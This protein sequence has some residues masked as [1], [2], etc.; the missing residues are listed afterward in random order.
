MK[1]EQAVQPYYVDWAITHRCNLRCVHCRGMHDTELPTERAL[2]LLQEIAALAPGWLIIEGGE[3][4]MRPDLFGILRYAHELGLK[5]FIISNGMLLTESA[6]RWCAGM[7]IRIMLSMDSPDSVTFEN[8]RRGAMFPTVLATA[9]LC[10]AAGI[11]DAINCT[12]S[13]HNLAQLPALFRLAA[14]I[15]ARRLH[16]LGLKP[17]ERYTEQLL[18]PRE[19]RQAI[20]ECCRAS[21]ETGVAFF[22]DEPFFNAAVREW[23]CTYVPEGGGSSITIAH[24]PGCILGKYLFITPGG[25]VWPCSFSPLVMGNVSKANL[26]SVWEKM[27]R[28]E[29]LRRLMDHCSRE[30][31]CRGCAYLAECGGCRARAYRLSKD[32]CASDPACP[33]HKA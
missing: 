22:F 25:D 24:E 17:C 18:S 33:L 15:G 27:R 8:L 26:V 7:G 1:P 30:G 6:V 32:W 31:A 9:R 28:S 2:T 13:R 20:E 16:I 19:Y 29:R 12:L 14:E 5:I 23:G 3:P 21:R 10:A 4:L 11:L